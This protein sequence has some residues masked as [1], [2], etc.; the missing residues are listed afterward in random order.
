MTGHYAISSRIIKLA[1]NLISTYI[2]YAM[3]LSIRERYFPKI[4]K[5]V[6][7]LLLSKKDKCKSSLEGYRPVSNLHTF[8]KIFEAWIKENKMNHIH[9]NNILTK[10]HHG[11]F[12]HHSTMTAKAVTDYVGTKATDYDKQGAILST[13]LSAAFDMVDH[14]ILL[15]KLHYYS[16]VKS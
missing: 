9:I 5:E 8:N 6:P 7:I 12:A 10:E 16:E 14:R 13:D 1:P 4:L 11:G 15:N 3:N 2:T